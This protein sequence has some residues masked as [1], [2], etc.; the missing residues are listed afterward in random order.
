MTSSRKTFFTTAKAPQNGSASTSSSKQYWPGLKIPKPH[1]RIENIRVFQRKRDGS[2]FW[3]AQSLLG[4]IRR[5]GEATEADDD[6]Y[7]AIGVPASTRHWLYDKEPIERV[8]IKLVSLHMA[9]LLAKDLTVLPPRLRHS[10]NKIGAVWAGDGLVVYPAPFCELPQ[11]VSWKDES[12][13]NFYSMNVGDFVGRTGMALFVPKFEHKRYFVNNTILHS[14]TPD[15]ESVR[16]IDNFP[17]VSG[18]FHIADYDSPFGERGSVVELYRNNRGAGIV[19]LVRDLR[20][21]PDIL[22]LDVAP[23]EELDVVVELPTAATSGAEM[24]EAINQYKKA[25][26]LELKVLLALEEP[27]PETP[28]PEIPEPESEVEFSRA[29]VE[30][31]VSAALALVAPSSNLIPGSLLGQLSSSRLTEAISHPS[32][33]ASAAGGEDELRERLRSSLSMAL[34]QQSGITVQGFDNALSVLCLT[35]GLKK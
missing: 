21:P 25:C 34:G 8:D 30:S 35:L 17:Q 22:Y 2:S 23:D 31:T 28:I 15:M 32:E 6:F 14:V 18:L 29:D 9:A 11:R 12:G 26:E 16:V 4:E 33:F 13:D 7:D 19:P 24:I 27:E 10:F 3:E 1:L 20:E 5:M